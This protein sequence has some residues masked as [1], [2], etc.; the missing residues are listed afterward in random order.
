MSRCARC[1]ACGPIGTWGQD[2]GGRKK[3]G[4]E[5]CWSSCAL[6]CTHCEDSRVMVSG[7]TLALCGAALRCAVAAGKGPGQQG[8]GSEAAGPQHAHRGRRGVERAVAGRPW[9]PRGACGT[10]H[11]A[12]ACWSARSWS[13]CRLAWMHACTRWLHECVL[14]DGCVC[15]LTYAWSICMPGRGHSADQG[16]SAHPHCR[17]A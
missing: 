3:G 10:V 16:N 6:L 5:E 2:V 17:P 1:G 4:R 14:R 11:S 9:R 8:H 7:T 13:A 15:S 12:A